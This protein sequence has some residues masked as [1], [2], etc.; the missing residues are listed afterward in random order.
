MRQALVLGASLLA[1][2]AAPAWAQTVPTQPPAENPVEGEVEPTAQTGS[3]AQDALDPEE[4]VIVTATRREQ[5]L[6]DAPVAVS[7]A[8]AE[9]ITQAQIRDLIDL[10]SVVPSLRVQQSE[11]S[12]ET[13]FFIR[14]FGN[15][16]GNPGIEPS[17]GVFIDGVYRSRSAAQITDLANIQ[18]VEVLRGPQSTLFGKNASA[19]VISVITQQP[20]FEFG[21]S[22]EVAFGNYDQVVVK[23]DITGPITDTLAFS[24]EGNYNKRDGYINLLGLGEINDRDRHDVRGQLLFKP[25]DALSIRIIGDYSKIDELC[26]GSVNVRYGP[27]SAA[28]NF[29]AGGPAVVAER[30]FSDDVRANIL[31]TNDIKNYGGS[32]QVDYDF[33]GIVLSS[34]TAYRE[35][36]SRSRNDGD[37][38][39][40]DIIGSATSNVE[41]GTFTQELRV[42]S[43]FDG[44]INFLL[45]GFYFDEDIDF[46][47]VLVNGRQTRNY[48]NL[49]AGGTPT[50]SALNTIEGILRRPAGSFFAP[51]TGISDAFTLAN[52]SYSV[53][54]TVDFQPFE[55]LTLTAGFNYTEDEKDVT[56][57]V[58]STEPFSA[59]DLV[60]LG[61]AIGVP[62]N[63]ANTPRSAAVPNGNP[64]LPLRGLQFLPPFLNFPN[65]VES[66]RTRDD[67]F[68]YTLRA[69]YEV[70]DQLNVYATYAT[71]FKASSFNLS[72]DSRPAAADFIPGSSAGLP[73]PAASPIR[74]AGLALP[75][76]SSG[77]RLAGPEDATVYEAGLKGSYGIA[78]FNIA[79]FQQEIEG[80]QDNTFTGTGF[81]LTN[82][83]LQS[84]FGV[85]FE[86]SLR[87]FDPLTLFFSGTYLDAKYDSFV[88]S[89]VGDLSG[90]DVAGVSP[91]TS[92]AGFT[93]NQPFG[94]NN[95]FILRGDYRFESEVEIEPGFPDQREVNEFNAAAT[96]RFDSGLELSV[97]GR[98]LTN[99]RYLSAVF[100]GV[101]QAGSVFGY[102]NQPR[103]YGGVVRYRF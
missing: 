61:V 6:Q 89:S 60:A 102:T 77:T 74:D 56:S 70:S 51:G 35:V 73:R 85:E 50:V 75:N 13:N 20:Q 88:G 31:P 58:V 90:Q 18:R 87:P 37:F 46:T 4:E 65:A 16:A 64:F 25:V 21:G 19:G 66:G 63:L 79:V 69:A 36:R 45:G 7:V 81:A 101:A 30:P 47:D 29:L 40:V 52:Q 98:N 96:V 17:V 39:S 57:N 28:L 32:A 68:S 34:I 49:L 22:A 11:T 3:A 103:T 48:V 23:G 2:A 8:T 78:T 26:C 67:N 93:F 12:A 71:G 100:N 72:R 91:F 86:G 38:T 55:G 5:T 59:V 92:S 41:I 82:A 43:D 99:D 94:N 9:T 44:P 83:G 54:G 76:L 33:G 53:F 84:T 14:G 10:Q 42:T 24:L 1:L 97:Y 27:T 80:F 15:G 95:R 62:A